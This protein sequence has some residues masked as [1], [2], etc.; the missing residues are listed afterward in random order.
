MILPALLYI[1]LLATPAYLDEIDPTTKIRTGLKEFIKNGVKTRNLTDAVHYLKTL[2]NVKYRDEQFCETCKYVV[3]GVLQ[4]RRSGVQRKDMIKLLT[5]LCIIFSG[6]NHA[7][8]TG[9]VN[10]EIDA[11]LYMM[12]NRKN[13][14]ADRICGIYL[15]HYGCVDPNYQ[16]WHINIPEQTSTAFVEPELSGQSL[17]I[18]HLTD[19][20]F[21]PE[22][23]PGSNAVCE[24]PLCCRGGTSNKPENA[25]GYWGDYH[26]CDMPWHSVLNLMDQ[27][28]QQ[29]QQID[30]VYYTGDI[31]SHASWLTTKESNKND[32]GRLFE[33]FLQRFNSISVYPVLG[34]HEAHPCNY[35]SPE[36]VSDAVSSQWLYDYVADDW[37]KWLPE[38]TKLTIRNGGF[39]TVLVR[40]GF[41][42]IGINSNLCYTDNIWLFFDDV[43]PHGQLQWLVDTLAE[44]EKNGEVVHLLAHVPPGSLECWHPWDNEFVRIVNRFSHVIK[45]QF[46]GHTH[47]DEIRIFLNDNKDNAVNVAYNGASFTTFVGMN[48]NYR[49]YD[50]DSKSFEVTDYEEWIFNLTE[51]NQ[52]SNT[53]PN[54]YKLYS[55]KHAYGLNSTRNEDLFDWIQRM[56]NDPNKELMKQYF[57]FLNRDSEVNINKGCDDDCLDGLL[58]FIV[59][60]TFEDAMKCHKT[61]TSIHSSFS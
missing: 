8:C 9:R 7:G 22:Y 53:P 28:K 24:D 60:I 57:R 1:V 23:K 4:Y 16:E 43:D 52:N 21:D 29:H 30:F 5:E 39:Y 19:I 55:F 47:T 38:D 13:L 51:A 49:L 12:D 58:C 36:N 42:I 45:A 61:N 25:A 11:L 54:W 48:P 40:K 10:I 46:N 14:T 20:H 18:L 17:K 44:A 15:Q 27:I 6:W 50:T 37:S 3:D 26:V 34:N 32:I 35:Y 33:L 59:S 56:K 41:R 2:P 31:I